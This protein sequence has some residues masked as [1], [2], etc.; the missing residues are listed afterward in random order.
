MEDMDKNLLGCFVTHTVDS[1]VV[2]NPYNVRLNIT[3]EFHVRYTCAAIRC[4]VVACWW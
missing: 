2:I 3:A 4:C 1:D